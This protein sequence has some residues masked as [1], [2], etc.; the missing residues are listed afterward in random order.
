MSEKTSWE[1]SIPEIGEKLSQEKQSHKDMEQIIQE[2]E[3]KSKFRNRQK[4]A[5]GK[6]VIVSPEGEKFEISRVTDSDSPDVE[7]MRELM[8]VGFEGEF[9]DEDLD[10]LETMRQA[11]G[12]DTFIYNIAKNV[13]GDAIQLTLG[14][15]LELGQERKEKKYNESLLFMGITVSREKRKGLGAELNKS[16]FESGLEK[17][18]KEGREIK[19]IAAAAVD[20]SEYLGNYVGMRRVYFENEKGEICEVPYIDPP[21]TWNF[22]TGEAEAEALPAHFMLN[23]VNGENTVLVGDFMEMVDVIYKVDS[24][25]SPESRKDDKAPTEEAIRRNHEIIEKIKNELMESLSQAKNGKI[26]LLDKKEREALAK[27]LQIK[28]KKIFENKE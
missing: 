1:L 18:K 2:I 4:T 6:E 9:K 28:G 26:M 21:L 12:N 22:E 10:S 25:I 11:V 14:Y 24:M 19:A 17:A 23:M 27:E 15:L 7:K 3:R 13:E 8:L 16:V 20:Q 5:D